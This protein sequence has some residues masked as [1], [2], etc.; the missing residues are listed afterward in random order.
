MDLRQHDVSMTART[1]A[2]PASRRSSDQ[3]ARAPFIWII[4][5]FDREVTTEIDR[6]V[7]S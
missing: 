3:A 1:H 4:S 7:C 2:T 5:R 6:D